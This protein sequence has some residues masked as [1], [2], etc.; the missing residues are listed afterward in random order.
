MLGMRALSLFSGVGGLDLAAEAAG[1]R[2]V[3]MCEIDPF[4][5]QIL[6]MRFPG[7]PIIEDVR[8]I[9]GDE[10]GAVDIVHGGFPCQDLSEA[11]RQDGLSDERSGLWFDM[12]N[13]VELYRP[14]YVLAEN[15][16]GAINLAL[17]TVKSGLEIA[18]YEVVTLLLPVSPFGAPH[19]RYRIG[20][21]GVR[22]DVADAQYDRCQ[23]WLQEKSTAWTEAADPTLSCGEGLWPTPTVFGNNN[24]RGCSDK[25]GDGLGTA[26]RMWMTPKASDSYMGRTAKQSDRPAEMTTQLQSQVYHTEGKRATGQLNP[27]WE[28]CLMGFPIGW[29][30]P[31]CVT[32]LEWPGWPM[33]PGLDQYDYE[34]PRTTKKKPH[35]SERVKAMGNTAMPVQ[36]APF[37]RVIAALE[38]NQQKILVS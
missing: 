37:F 18:G 4:C 7:V 8:S 14:A 15:V 33:P 23:G 12:L 3:A 35:R 2:T 13:V 31:G 32:P 6:G 24:R 9:R 34:P 26:V 5:R 30:D 17:D 11:G 19:E 27:D 10:F 22:R 29:T 28:E 36:F 38:S 21:F 16:R 25:S 20:V 1:I